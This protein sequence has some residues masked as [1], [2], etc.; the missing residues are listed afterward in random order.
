MDQS[1]YHQSPH[2]ATSRCT[3]SNP[4][5]ID[6]DNTD[7][8]D[9]SGQGREVRRERLEAAATR[10]SP[11]WPPSSLI[12]CRSNQRVDEVQSLGVGQSPRVS[13]GKPPTVPYL[14]GQCRIWRNVEHD[15]SR[16]LGTPVCNAARG[17]ITLHEVSEI[18]VEIGKSV[19][20]VLSEA[21]EH[22]PYVLVEPR[23][24]DLR[25]PV[26]LLFVCV[27]SLRNLSRNAAISR[28]TSSSVRERL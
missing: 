27:P 13:G 8:P 22:F 18:A 23:L 24:N 25:S 28:V 2:A 21:L 1:E 19:G 26:I 14:H 6:Q 9:T 10:P 12:D 4:S 7:D 17:E 11:A 15:S 20:E 3:G 5:I 16:T